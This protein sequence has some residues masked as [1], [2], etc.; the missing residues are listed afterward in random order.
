MIEQTFVSQP[1][2][3]RPM[4]TWS[5]PPAGDSDLADTPSIR[6]TTRKSLAWVRLDLEGSHGGLHQGGSRTQDEAGDDQSWAGASEAGEHGDLALP[7]PA[8]RY[9]RQG[10]VEEDSD[11][12]VPHSREGGFALVPTTALGVVTCNP[13]SQTRKLRPSVVEGLA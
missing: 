10:W 7:V 4:S 3:G 1:F 12:T 2:L 5:T 13:M 9:Q 8:L 6:C 11:L